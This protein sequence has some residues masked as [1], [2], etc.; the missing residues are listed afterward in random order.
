M[1]GKAFGKRVDATTPVAT[2]S[3][4]VPA[5]VDSDGV[6]RVIP[7]AV[8][9]G[10]YGAKLRQL[11][12]SP[13]D[14]INMALTPER[15]NAKSEE[16]T[17]NMKAL[18]AKVN[19]HIPSV[20]VVPWAMMPWAVWNG[21]NAE[22]LMKGDF[23]PS[24]PWNNMLLAADAKSS[25]FLGLPEHPRVAMPAINENVT[26]LITELRSNFQI[27]H[28]KVMQQILRGDFSGLDSFEQVRK[29]RFQKLIML[30]RHVANMVFGEAA[31]ARHDELFG[32]G[33]SKVTN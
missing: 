17:R 4:Y 8:W 6:T 26:R 5:G 16:V 25:A 21:L 11:G 15:A 9:N 27:E 1:L 32:I 29:D 18:V 33:L 3:G 24:S 19:A 28:E 10:P 12:F 20:S 30:T 14:A 13:D 2:S 7:L 22:F 31:C 23:F